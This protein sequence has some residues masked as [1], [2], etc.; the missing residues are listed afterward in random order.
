VFFNPDTGETAILLMNGLDVIG[1]IRIGPD[2][3]PVSRFVQWQRDNYGSETNADAAP[4]EDPDKDWAT[5]LVEYGSGVEDV[6]LLT[7]RPVLPSYAAGGP[8]VA[9]FDLR[10]DDPDLQVILES[11]VN[12]VDWDP[13][14]YTETARSVV[15]ATTD[16]VTI[17]TDAA[18]TD[19]AR[20]YRVRFVLGT[21]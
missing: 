11:S 10:S 5:N 7:P 13:V 16:R 2:A 15:D 6:F 3:G 14:A 8:F 20:Y 1:E 17:E 4:G 21:P 9:S 19:E 18:P 12:F